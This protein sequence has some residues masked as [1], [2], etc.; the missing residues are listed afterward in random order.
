[1]KEKQIKKT[2]DRIYFREK[3]NHL[4]FLKT[5]EEL[6]K[7]NIEKELRE[8]TFRPRINSNF[9]S[10]NNFRSSQKNDNYSK[11]FREF[12]NLNFSKTFSNNLNETNRL[13]LKNEDFTIN[14]GNLIRDNSKSS[15]KENSFVI[16]HS[17]SPDKSKTLK[18]KFKGNKTPPIFNSRFA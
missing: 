3:S 9:S 10:E 5:C 18:N 16:D 13:F 4:P 7:I 2:I 17:I 11:K 12:K 15:S 14:I 6:H 8:A 1:M